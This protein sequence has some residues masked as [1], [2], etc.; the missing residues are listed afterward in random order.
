MCHVRELLTILFCTLPLM[1]YVDRAVSDACRR[2]FTPRILSARKLRCQI[3]KQLTFL[4]D[5]FSFLAIVNFTISMAYRVNVYKN[6]LDIMRWFSHWRRTG[7]RHNCI[8]YWRMWWRG[9]LP[10]LLRPHS[11][12]D[13]FANDS[14]NRHILGCGD[15][16]VGPMTPNSNTGEIALLCNTPNK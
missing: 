7:G 3:C 4:A 14:A 16:G 10:H 2:M 8:T 5:L 11:F 9:P 1:W 13:F 12:V 6:K 15:P